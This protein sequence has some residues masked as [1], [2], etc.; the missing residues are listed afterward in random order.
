MNAGP[1]IGIYGATGRLGQLIIS[2]ATTEEQPIHIIDR[3]L[4]LAN[5]D[6]IIDVTSPEGTAA[7][8]EAATQS[9]RAPAIVIGTTGQLPTEAINK[10][11]ESAAVAVVSNFSIGIPLLLDLVQRAVQ[12]L[13][14]GWDIEV[15]EVH[16]NQKIDAPSGTAK[17][18]SR[19]IQDCDG[20]A[21]P[22][23]VPVH[24]LRVG[25]T[26]GEHT[27]WLCGPGERIEIKHVATRR[28]VFAI[29]ALRWAR[30]L[31]T[32]PTGCLRP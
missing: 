2:T 8:L 5:C 6:V 14:E 30:W 1:K 24:S 10:Y 26:F 29:G 3:R 32:Q 13:P 27:V 25:D 16:H 4:D 23:S 22:A 20:P 18:I 11:A 7:L 21:V 19:A 12:L 9:P 28:E 15:I 17:R 31:L